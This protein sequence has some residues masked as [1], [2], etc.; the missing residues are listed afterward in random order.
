M[1]PKD[2]PNEITPYI[3][4]QVMFTRY[5]YPKVLVKQSLFLALLDHN[6]DESLYW[7]Y[8]LYFSGFEDET[9]DF[10]FKLYHDIYRYDNPHLIKFME[11]IRADWY[12]NTLQYWLIGS[13]IATLCHCNYR[14]NKFVETHF[15]V[16]CE[17]IAKPK[18]KALVI[19]L[20]EID[21][22][23]Y[24]INRYVQ[25][26][27][28]Y[29][30]LVCKYGVRSN[31]MRLFMSDIPELRDKWYHNWE[32]YACLSP[33]WQERF[34]DFNAHINM[35][36]QKVVFDDDESKEA[37]YERWNLE[38]DEQS[39][40]LQHAILGDNDCPQM[41]IREFCEKYGAPLVTK[42]ITKKKPTPLTNNIVYNT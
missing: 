25:P 1:E 4:D 20:K 36:L 13:I 10:V 29:L 2:D 14:I 12:K 3:V 22:H 24:K 39:L 26:P 35:D 31:V 41:T 8:E 11:S 34:D 5:L 7:A 18:K 15:K 23:E 28:S 38:P 33:L 21:I 32:F 6:Y 42:T 17:H 30:P 37:F 9:Y 40:A 19:R 16:H 27:R